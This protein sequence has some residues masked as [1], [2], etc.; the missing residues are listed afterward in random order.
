MSKVIIKK[1]KESKRKEDITDFGKRDY[2]VLFCEG[3]D[4]LDGCPLGTSEFRC[5]RGTHFLSN[6]A[7]R[8][9]SHTIDIAYNKVLNYRK[10]FDRA[11]GRIE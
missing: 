11:C 8:M 7:N 10:D 2:L 9:D 4:C 5:G 1:R 3:Q 6:G